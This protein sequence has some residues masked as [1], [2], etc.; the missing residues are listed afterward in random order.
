MPNVKLRPPSK[1][2]GHKCE[3]I[4]R[5]VPEWFGREDSLIE[6]VNE[7]DHLST[8]TAFLDERLIGFFSVNIHNECSAELHVLAVHLDFHRQGIGKQLY[9]SVEE[10]LK[11]QGIKYVQVKTL[12]PSYGDANY[13]K[14]RQFYL[15]LGFSPLEE[16]REFWGEGTPCLLMVKGI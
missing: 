4:L 13:E 16:I 9:R 12:G 15:S 5:S 10:D 3:K 11:T 2:L 6:Y 14:T 8:Y 7:I 1:G